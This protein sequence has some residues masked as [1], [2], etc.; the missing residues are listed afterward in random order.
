MDSKFPNN[1]NPVDGHLEE[2]QP[3]SAPSSPV[4]TTTQR[5]PS[6]QAINEA[7]LKTH[8]AI[9]EQNGEDGKRRPRRAPTSEYIL[10]DTFEKNNS[11]FSADREERSSIASETKSKFDGPSP[12]IVDLGGKFNRPGLAET[13][14]RS[15]SNSGLNQPLIMGERS[16]GG[17]DHPSSAN[18]PG[19]SQLSIDMKYSKRQ[20]SSSQGINLNVRA[21]NTGSKVGFWAR[22]FGKQAPEPRTF[23]LTGMHVFWSLALLANSFLKSTVWLGTL[24]ILLE[25]KSITFTALFLWSSLTRYACRATPL[26]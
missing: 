17:G 6:L 5:V 19:A 10:L 1:D 4:K 8:D 3:V 22:M 2:K 14:K 20:Q 9:S 16:G 7:S 12:F 25:T 21:P 26:R 24:Q 13:K 11:I 23:P 18:Q 15:S